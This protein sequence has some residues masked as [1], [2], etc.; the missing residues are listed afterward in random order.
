MLH[1]SFGAGTSFLVLREQVDGQP[2]GAVVPLATEFLSGAHRGRFNPK[3]GQLYVSG[4]AGWGS[5][6][7]AD[8][9]FDRVRYTGDPVQLPIA[10]HAHQNGVL[11]TFTRPLDRAVA[12][13]PKGHFAQAWNYRYGP[14]YGSP[15]LSPRHPGIPGHDPLEIRSATVLGDGR[16]LFLEIPDLQP[17]NQLHLHL[18]VD[19]GPRRT[20]SPRSTSSRPPS[21]ASPAIARPPRRSPPTR[22]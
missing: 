17:V 8:G 4:L 21:P 10:Y 16:S 15:E 22:S 20:S 9:S 14:A 7:V 2:Q 1:F 13:V 5:Y 6:T 11:V 18:R 12:E 3:D 19:D